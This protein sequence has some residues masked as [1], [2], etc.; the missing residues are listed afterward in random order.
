LQN[1]NAKL[2]A[3]LILAQQIE[4]FYQFRRSMEIKW[5]NF[6]IGA[7]W[8]FAAL[9]SAVQVQL[10]PYIVWILFGICC[11]IEFF[12][13]RSKIYAQPQFTFFATILI[14]GVLI[15]TYS[16][17]K[18]LYDLRQALQLA[19]LALGGVIFFASSATQRNAFLVA[20]FALTTLNAGLLFLGRFVSPVFAHLATGDGRFET[21][22][23]Q[24]G[25]MGT[26]A[27]P[28]LIYA[29][30]RLSRSPRLWTFWIVSSCALSL[31][32]AENSRTI[33]LQVALSLLFVIWVRL[34]EVQSRV[35]RTLFAVFIGIILLLTAILAAPKL[36]ETRAGQLVQTL[37]N[38]GFTSGLE[39]ADPIRVAMWQHLFEVLPQN[40]FWG[41]GLGTTVI[42]I[43]VNGTD[44]MD[45]HAGALQLW[46]D[47]G[48]LA[49][50]GYF[51]L[52]AASL[53]F[54]AKAL[55]QRNLQEHER[56]VLLTATGISWTFAF[57]NFLHTYSTEWGQWIYLAFAWGTI[58]FYNRNQ[59]S[60]IHQP[61]WL[62]R[63]RYN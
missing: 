59:P 22:L 35:T 56:A 28:L 61:N 11:F 20:L 23:N 9:T 32:I 37:V 5:I 54:G 29:T 24:P 46:A 18:P 53:W 6:L 41:D 51:G 62:S 43:G 49:F 12:L 50:L 13:Y 15:N 4:P 19:V 40:V 8:S 36:L 14:V 3:W 60:R 31:V 33:T 38:D 63:K 58:I 27:I 21:L 48:L 2:H 34:L 57:G 7:I 16:S 1:I 44:F 45:V 30:Y 47:A 55:N 17:L 52:I 10:S 42:P 25:T 39:I 26:L